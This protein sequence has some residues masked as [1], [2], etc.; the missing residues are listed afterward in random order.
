[1][2]QS[3]LIFVLCAL[4]GAQTHAGTIS[5]TVRAEG[6]A[7]AESDALC[8]KY[9]S[10]QFKFADRVDYAG[11]RDFIVYI[12]GPVGGR[13]VSPPE[14]PAQVITSRVHQKG[15]MFDPHVLPVVVGTTVEWPNNDDIFHNVFSASDICTFDLE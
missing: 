15:A 10:R 3:L 7:G 14:K 13:P 8:G 4:T 6:K 5:G 12:E 11:M 1:M 9:G 2:N